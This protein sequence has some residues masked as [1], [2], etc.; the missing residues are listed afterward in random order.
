MMMVQRKAAGREPFTARRQ[1][2]PKTSRAEHEWLLDWETRA[3][4]HPE[5][6]LDLRLRAS[7]HCELRTLSR[8]HAAD[9]K[10]KSTSSQS[11]TL[12]EWR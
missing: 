10:R 9:W 7:P 4:S 6:V 11:T 1:T 12:S 2:G 5:A 8:L 3:A